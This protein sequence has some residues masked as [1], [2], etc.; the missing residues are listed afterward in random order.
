MDN[1]LMEKLKNKLKE[2]EEDI[3]AGK[4]INVKEFYKLK[5]HLIDTKKGQ[6]RFTRTSYDFRGYVG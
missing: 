3:F 5:K 1:G 4:D 2:F 6:S